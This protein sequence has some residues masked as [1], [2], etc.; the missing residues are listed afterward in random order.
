MRRMICGLAV[1]SM[2]SGCATSQSVANWRP[3]IDTQGGVNQTRYERDLQECRAYAEANPDANPETAA[4]DGAKDS[5]LRNGA[6]GAGAMAVAGVL[7]GG[8]ALVPMAIAGAMGGAI[9]GMAGGFAGNTVA[10]AHYRSIVSN[11]L[12]GRG[13]RV[14][15]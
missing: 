13:Y 5:A 9:G 14:L 6:M 3:V 1:I 15:Y 8:I 12:S 11:C 2:V 4:T 10:E 7:T